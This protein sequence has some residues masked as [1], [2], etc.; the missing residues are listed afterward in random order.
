MRLA[1]ITP[2]YV[3][4]ESYSGGLANYLGRT[5][6]ALAQA[7][8]D[9]QV[10][11]K[12]HVNET[13]D[14]QG[15][16]VHRTVPLW[17]LKMRIDRIDRLTPRAI[18]S[19]YQDLKAAW[20]LWRRWKRSDAATPFD[21]VQVANVLAV[22]L[23]FRFATYIP[24]VTRLSSYRPAWDAAAGIP[25]TLSVRLRWWMEKLAIRGTRHIYSPTD[26][27]ARLTSEN[28]RIQNIKVIETPFFHEECVADTTDYDR[29]GRGRRY[30]L[31]FGRM[32]QM[33]GV[34]LLAE[35]LPGLLGEYPALHA[36]FVGGDAVAP[37]GGQMS[38]YIRRVTV[39]C[40]DR[41]SLLPSVRHDRLYP[42]VRNAAVVAIPSVIDNMPNTCLEAM[43][44]G[45][46]VVATTGSCFEQLI[47]DGKSGILTTP[48]DAQSLLSGLRQALQLGESATIDM[49]TAAI[50]RISQLSPENAIPR[51]VE[52]Y[53]QLRQEYPARTTTAASGTLEYA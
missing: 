40:S 19:P 5:T 8:H 53:E 49:G 22:G 10:F 48:N 35:I 18:Y 45:R 9:V 30:L 39:S 34:H 29:Y 17:D 50:A 46:I 16:T 31:F 1:F 51:L 23:F 2:E 20:S 37:D 25:M 52:Y 6:V 3:T 21:V 7:G 14:Y 11:T 15:V 26:Y 41:I 42:L 33:K 13:I 12:S 27:V 4:E 28:Y 44:L 32:T 38:E 36:V 47:E 43:A 24:V